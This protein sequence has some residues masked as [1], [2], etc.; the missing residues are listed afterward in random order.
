MHCYRKIATPLKVL[1]ICSHALI[2]DL[3]VVQQVLL[4]I[5][6]CFFF[7]LLKPTT[8]QLVKDKRNV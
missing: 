7:P 3:Q 2:F 8:E 1:L 5:M 6:P 4:P